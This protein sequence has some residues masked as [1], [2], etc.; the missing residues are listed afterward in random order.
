MSDQSFAIAEMIAAFVI[1]VGL[2]GY[3]L[4]SV[5]RDIRVAE[6]EKRRKENG[7]QPR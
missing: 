3:Q 7:Q 6:E 5:R 1:V 4:W 2:A